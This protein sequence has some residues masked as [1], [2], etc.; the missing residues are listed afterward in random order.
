MNLFSRQIIF[1]VFMAIALLPTTSLAQK[2]NN[3]CSTDGYTILTI[4]GIWTTKEEAAENKSALQRKLSNLYRDQKLKIDYLHNASHLGGLGDIIDSIRQGLFDKETINDYDLVEMMRAASEKVKTQKILLVAH[5]QGN[6]YANSFYNIVAGQ[7]GG[8]P[9]ESIGVYS[10]ATPSG[11]VAGGG[12]WITSDTDEVIADLVGRLLARPILRPNTHIALQPGDDSRGHDFSKIYL[13]YRS[14]EIVADIE[15]SLDRLQT[16]DAQDAQK[17]CLAPPPLTLGHRIEGTVFAIADPIASAGGTA[18][19]TAANGVY[20]AGAG[21]VR[22][23]TNIYNVAT[24]TLAERIAAFQR[25]SFGAAGALYGSSVTLNDLTDAPLAA[26]VGASATPTPEPAASK[27]PIQPDTNSAAKKEQKPAVP[28]TIA[29]PEQKIAIGKTNATAEPSRLSLPSSSPSSNTPATDSGNGSLP[30]S[31]NPSSGSDSDSSRSSSS[32]L[33]NSS[34]SSLPNSSTSTAS[35]SPAPS[36]ASS[37]P[38]TDTTPPDPPII[39]APSSDGAVSTSTTLTFAGTAEKAAIISNNMTSA[40]T[41][42]DNTGNWSLGLTGLTQGT[43]TILFYATDAAG[44]ISTSSS[45]IVVVDT[46]APSVSLTMS[47]CNQSLATS[48]CLLATTSLALAWSSASSDVNTYLVS[49]TSGGTTCTNFP[50][51]LGS[52]AATTTTYAA[53]DDNTN[54]IFS[55]TARDSNGNTS[56]A[57]TQTVSVATRPVVINEIAWAGTSSAR[58]EDEWM[59]LYNITDK[60]INLTNWILRSATDNTPYIPLSGTIAAKSFFLLER[61][62]DT[63]LSDIAANQIYTG[64]LKNTGEQL[65]LSYASTTIDKTPPPCGNFWCLG[66]TYHTMERNDPLASGTDTANWSSYVGM[67]GNGKNADNVAITG[68]PGKRNSI[69]YFIDPSG[70]N[71]FQSKTLSKTKNPYVIPDTTLT[72]QPG[73]T[74]TIE[75]GV[76]IKF[77]N[78]NSALTVNGVI[79]AAGTAA[80]PV[81]FTSFHDDD[82]GISGGCGDTDGTTTS[83]AA[84][85]WQNISF[86]NSS[87]I[88]TLTH[89]VIRYGGMKPPFNVNGAVRVVNSSVELQN[90]TIENNY[91]F[92]LWLE[93]STST[94]IT[95]SIIQ[96]HREPASGSY[97]IFMTHSSPS[98]KNTLF[99]NNT[100]AIYDGGGSSVVNLGGITFDGNTTDDSPVTLIP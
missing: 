96:N 87:V 3:L 85:D 99:K 61:T 74:L 47:A 2:Q 36:S 83:P 30:A 53:P 64:D 69:D 11:H 35:S 97:G 88:S 68:T 1:V 51:S 55:V 91:G 21:A 71:L 22:V 45:R 31:S 9:T 33:S 82:C 25:I 14:A 90:A 5:S 100:T 26:P 89:T 79:S 28:E 12:R 46:A 32:S 72:I 93:N 77:H 29:A 41:T 76:V 59:E 56:H 80:E 19:M 44:N 17:P 24:M 42:T 86:K 57:A 34:S 65:E 75:P 62:N 94:T 18:I 66:S 6:F 10:V 23:A 60:N 4:N 67:L 15:T 7:I 8:V 48:G 40:T 16:N 49:C 54:Y 73:V 20:D 78:I 43:S 39:T 52:T 98:I 58:P 13:K 92:G 38:S 50:S 37:T 95:D 81:V 27:I 63:T 84:G 70:S